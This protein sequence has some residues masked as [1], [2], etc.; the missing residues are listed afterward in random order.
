M[1]PMTAML[2][3]RGLKTL[4]LRM[5]RHCRTAQ[6]VAEQLHAHPAVA[7]VL[8]PGLTDFPQHDL[9][10]AQMDA[11]GGMIALELFGGLAAGRDLINGLKMIHC[12]VSL[13]DAETLIQHPASMTHSPYTEE[14]RIRHGIS[15]GL[16]RLSVGLEAPADILA[17]LVQSLDRLHV[18]T[19]HHAAE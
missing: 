15:D 12:A 1:A 19:L 13:G 16:V 9:S 6:T 4:E 17:D 8:Y 18:P 5:E 10:L 2:I 7:R 3:L 11:S 14:E